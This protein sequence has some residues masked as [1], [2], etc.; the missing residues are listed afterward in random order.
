MKGE[1]TFIF[2][3]RKRK[4]TV[5]IWMVC[6]ADQGRDI[7]K[8]DLIEI[9]S[10]NSVVLPDECYLSLRIPASSPVFPQPH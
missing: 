10:G 2:C 3:L 1:G 5:R 7:K 6:P 8:R 9:P 4:E